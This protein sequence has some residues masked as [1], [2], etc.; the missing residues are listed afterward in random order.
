MD[1]YKNINNIPCTE[2]GIE[3][4]VKYR[5]DITHGRYRTLDL[6]IVE[7]AYTLIALSYCSF[8]QRLGMQEADLKRLFEQNRIGW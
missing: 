7:V 5:N 1:I 4:F 3:T 6:N 2:A 8:F